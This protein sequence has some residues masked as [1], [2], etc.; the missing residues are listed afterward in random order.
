M[1]TF[2]I[3]SDLVAPQQLKKTIVSN[4]WVNNHIRF[5]LNQFILNGFLS[6][7]LSYEALEIQIQSNNLWF[8]LLNQFILNGS[9]S[10]V[11]HWNIHIILLNRFNINDSLSYVEL[12]TFD[13]F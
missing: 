3:L 4:V 8:I 5:I 7:S 1:F 12:E 11:K 10:H 6:L 13:S 9:L 2:T